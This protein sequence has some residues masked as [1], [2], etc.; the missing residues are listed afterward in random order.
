MILRC[1]KPVE[2]GVPHRQTPYLAGQAEGLRHGEGARLRPRR[3]ERHVG[4]QRQARGA[5]DACTAR[6]LLL[7]GMALRL[8]G[9]VLLA[10]LL[11]GQAERL[12]LGGG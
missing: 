8:R 6:C 7:R 10:A 5:G 12:R 4:G 9:A 3:D 11:G 2:T 1:V